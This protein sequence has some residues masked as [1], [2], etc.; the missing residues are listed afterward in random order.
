MPQTHFGPKRSSENCATPKV[1]MNLGK[2]RRGVVK[3]L[4]VTEVTYYRW[5]QEYGAMTTEG[6]RTGKGD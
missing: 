5:R 6:L 2:K 3:A 4:G 1:L